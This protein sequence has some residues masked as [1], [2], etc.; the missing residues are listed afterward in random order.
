MNIQKHVS[1]NLNLRGLGESATLAINERCREMKKCG[2]EVL[3]LGIG[4]SPFPVPN[5][6]VKALK[7]YATERTYLPVKGLPELRKAVADYHWNKDFNNSQQ[8]T[9][10]Y[11]F[12]MR[13]IKSSIFRCLSS[14]ILNN[15]MYNLSF[16]FTNCSITS[17]G[18]RPAKAIAI[19]NNCSL[20]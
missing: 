12:N 17:I 7:M 13:Q 14:I 8:F 11:I 16:L 5:F 4:E 15:E 1:L 9:F 2:I 6:V 19:S 20:E 10:P 18:L 3:N